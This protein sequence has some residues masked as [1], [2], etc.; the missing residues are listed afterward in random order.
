MF[1]RDNV[2]FHGKKKFNF[3]PYFQ[4]LFDTNKQTNL[5]SLYIGIGM[6][7]E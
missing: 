1:I 2:R 6:L 4:S 5:S 7:D 3:V